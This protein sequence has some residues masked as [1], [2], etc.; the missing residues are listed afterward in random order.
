MVKAS[1]AS[2]HYT[3]HAENH[4]ERCALCRHFEGQARTNYTCAV[5]MGRVKPTGWCEEFSRASADR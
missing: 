5:V 2:V 1:K 4:K 3:D